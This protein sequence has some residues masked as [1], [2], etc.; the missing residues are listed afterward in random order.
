MIPFLQEVLE[1]PVALRRALASTL[2]QADALRAVARELH[3]GTFRQVLLTGMGSS[4][5]AGL[6][7]ALHCI[8]R[9]PLPVVS[10]ETSELVYAAPAALTPPT[11][12]IAVSQSGESAELVRLAQRSS[13]PA[14]IISVTNGTANTLA[15]WADVAVDTAAGPEATVT[16]KTYT[17][18]LVALHLIA[19]LLTEDP[20][21]PAEAAIT[22]LAD[23]LAA[24]LPALESSLPAALAALGPGDTLACVGRGASLASARE[25]ALI[26]EESCKLP[27]AAYSGA[28]LRHGPLERV[29]PGFR[30]LVFAGDDA[31]T[32]MQHR[33]A[34]T[35]VEHGGRCLL[36]TPRPA[37]LPGVPDLVI[38]AAPPALLPISEIIP[39]QLLTIPLAQQRGFAPATFRYSTK[40]T[41]TE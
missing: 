37:H 17:A 9:L 10:W 22:T 23:D 38:P 14:R 2:A 40:V 6:P 31:A 12:L 11:L 39:V 3:A 4:W 5:Y 16:S 25:A 15:R 28:Q 35:L 21:P 26:L 36:I 1:Q 13:R 20:L 19:C 29:E 24:F 18:S 34:S 7:A 32:P 33:L 30:A 8:A 27:A 41:T